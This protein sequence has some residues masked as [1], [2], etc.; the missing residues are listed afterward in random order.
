MK[1]LFWLTILSVIYTYLGYP[2]LLYVLS[3]VC[4]RDWLR[5]PLRPTI[6]ILLAVRNG[7]PMLQAKLDHLLKLDYPA[8]LTEIIVVSDGS[9][10]GTNEV[11]TESTHPRL[12]VILGTEH[13]GKAAALNRGMRIATGEIL[14]FNDIRPYLAPGA[15]AQL[16]SNF[17][18]PSVG[19]VA[20]N[21]RV[22][23]NG[24]DAVA[25][26]V[27]GAYWKHEQ[28]LRHLESLVDSPVGVYGGFYAVRRQLATEFPEG[29]ILDDMFQPLCIIR[30]GYRSVLEE[31]ALVWD[32]WP[33]STED[34]FERKVRTLAGNYQLLQLAPW[35]LSHQNRVRF[36]YISHKLM[37]LWAPWCLLLILV[38]S[39]A[40]RNQ[41]VYLALLVAQLLFYAA[42]FAGVFINFP[43]LNKITAIPGAICTL[44]A[45]ALVGLY[46]FLFTR[47]PLWKIWSATNPV[48]SG[49]AEAVRKKRET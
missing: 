5:A 10:D 29:I 30:K 45:A 41:P 14:L 22:A 21:L 24:Q 27:G 1:I 39:I 7:K 16:L 32:R 36:Q 49:Q 17:A 40:L 3:R 13:Q 19:C 12:H 9:S 18:D 38:V 44:N 43:L 47:G 20:G 46:R 42:A 37:R 6:S 28:W 15:V 35:L 23:P 8:E 26:V 4:R 25:S 34:E 48:P 2:L 11:L 33:A 31:G